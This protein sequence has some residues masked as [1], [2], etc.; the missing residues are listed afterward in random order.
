MDSHHNPQ[1]VQIH[2]R[3][4]KSNQ[5]GLGVDIV[6]GATGRPLCPVSAILQYISICSS[7]PGPFFVTVSKSVLSKSQFVV[8]IRAILQLLGLPQQDYAGHSFQIGAA[9]PAAAAGVEDST[10]QY[11]VGGR[12]QCFYSIFVRQRNSWQLSPPCWSPP[13]CLNL[14]L[15]LNTWQNIR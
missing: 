5:F 12:V 10:I 8:R 11:W 1:M 7:Q 13:I 6:L 3:K 2:L 15:D 9:T 14:S 4:S